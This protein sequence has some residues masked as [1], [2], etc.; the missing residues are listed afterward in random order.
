MQPRQHKILS[1]IQKKIASVGAFAVGELYY[2][3]RFKQ[4]FKRKWQDAIVSDMMSSRMLANNVQRKNGGFV[5]FGGWFCCGEV[6]C[7]FG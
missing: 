4:K 7:A 2:A 1:I 5:L 6:G 3:A